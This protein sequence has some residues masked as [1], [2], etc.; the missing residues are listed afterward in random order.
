MDRNND[1]IIT[2]AE[3]NGSAQSFRVHDWNSDGVLSGDEVRVGGQRQWDQDPDY[4][5]NRN[6]LSDWTERR[7][8]QLDSNG[9]GRILRREW[10]FS[11]EEFLRVDRN[12]DG[13]LTRA[14]F[15]DPNANDDRD[16]QFDYLDLN[17]N[18]RVEA[19]E[20][21]A[22]RETFQWLDRNR[23]GV[24]SRTEAAGENLESNDQF[25]GARRQQRPSDRGLG[26][27]VVASELRPARPQQRRPADP[28]RV[29]RGRP[30]RRR[31]APR[32][33]LR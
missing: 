4:A 12:R 10:P 32:P 5:P 14:E 31:P 30:D 13:A 21:H 28:G 6:T 9:D 33:R 2:R 15:L 24:L 8:Q 20:W 19:S 16:D 26:M 18:N 11:A 3:W 27:A 22:S 1:G 25:A 7:F 17:G 23:D 29:R